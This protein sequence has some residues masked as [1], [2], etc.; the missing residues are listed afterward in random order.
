MNYKKWNIA[1]ISGLLLVVAFIMGM[2]Y[3][4][5]PFGYFTFQSGDYDKIGFPMNT[6]YFMREFKAQH[7]LKH[8]DEYD[9]Y[10]IA[11]SKG[12]AYQA[13]KF[14]ALDGYR[15]YNCFELGGSFYEYEEM[16]NFLV[17]EVSPKKIVLNISGG[18]VRAWQR[19]VKDLTF[20]L[21]AVVTGESKL[22][23]TL[24]FLLKDVN[25]SFERIEDRKKNK[26]VGLRE[27]G[28]RNLQKY[29]DRIDNPE[30]WE[31]Y[32]NN[33]VLKPFDKH[34]KTLFTTDVERDHYDA[35]LASMKN[36]KK[37]CD[38]GGVELQVIVAPSF[39][40][41]MSEHDTT[42]YRDFLIQLGLITDYW[43]FSGY[44]EINMNPYNYY[45]E[46]HF[47]YE[48]ADLLIDTMAG[49]ASYP[50]FGVYVT[51]ENVSDHI[52]ERTAD[53]ERLQEEYLAT[54]TIQLPG[55]EDESCLV[56]NQ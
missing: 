6:S 25:E 39:I 37:T 32:V 27:G 43:D 19:N 47:F 4:V 12:G 28:E 7:I 20:Q 51:K 22:L 45:N 41:E 17:E 5:D 1:I 14:Q 50:G 21:P 16:V 52:A 9:A 53:Y 36:I 11:G 26:Y 30:S 31:R 3:F 2:N 48:V 10:F 35:C 24:D 49:K 13:E 38:D 55:M 15:Y 46:G 42:Y 56:K 40:G 23:E 33:N 44:N 34:M 8:Q 54:G 18:E 29:Y